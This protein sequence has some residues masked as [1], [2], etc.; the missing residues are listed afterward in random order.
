MMNK[1]L[2]ICKK[3]KKCLNEV[4]QCRLKYPI[5]REFF[6]DGVDMYCHIKKKKI[7]LKEIQRVNNNE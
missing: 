3:Y 6:Y 1:E 5:W 7:Y 2:F 4:N